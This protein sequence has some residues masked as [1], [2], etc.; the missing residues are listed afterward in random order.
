MSPTPALSTSSIS[1]F[2]HPISQRRKDKLVPKRKK[3]KKLLSFLLNISSQKQ[4][5]VS[6]LGRSMAYPS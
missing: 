3:R 6:K 5:E 2:G 4:K 1:I